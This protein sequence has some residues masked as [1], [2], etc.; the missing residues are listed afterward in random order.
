MEIYPIV[1]EIDSLEHFAISKANNVTK[2]AN[3]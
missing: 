1:A 3:C 2:Y